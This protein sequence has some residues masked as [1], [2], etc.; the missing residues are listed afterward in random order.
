M[1]APSHFVSV[2]FPPVG[3]SGVIAYAAESSNGANQNDKK[4][5]S[6]KVEV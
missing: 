4:A 5:A 3:R 2:I 1:N 6:D